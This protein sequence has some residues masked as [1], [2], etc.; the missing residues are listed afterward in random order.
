MLSMLKQNRGV[1]L[2]SSLIN[3]QCDQGLLSQIEVLHAGEEPSQT[4]KSVLVIHTLPDDPDIQH[5]QNHG[6]KK[7]DK[8]V[9]V[10][11]WQQEQFYLYFGIPYSVGTV[12]YNGIDAIP[13][14][15]KSNPE[16]GK[17]RLMYFN[18]PERGLDYLYVAFDQLSKEFKNLRL[19]VYCDIH[20]ND[21]QYVELKKHLKSHGNI[22][23]HETV[24]NDKIRSALEKAHI[25]A[26]PCVWQEVSCL[27]LIEALSAGCYCVHP[28]LGALKE[29][30]LGITQM[31]SFQDERQKHID[32]FY[33]ELK[34][35]VLLHNH[36]YDYVK[37]NTETMKAIADFKY[38][39][40]MR[41]DQWN[42]LFEN[43]LSGG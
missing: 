29:T 2:V 10:S 41:K 11:H 8:L 21:S 26:Y 7:Y 43:V 20:E 37:S 14:H 38:D 16:K 17:I 12:I 34:K 13:L 3:E 23:Y 22:V 9:F 5:L 19:D 40:S 4:K 1:K 30:S 18:P 31:Y 35:A 33:V 27:S 25:F 15:S 32:N 24:S 6:Y 39:W 36:S 42:K 28:A